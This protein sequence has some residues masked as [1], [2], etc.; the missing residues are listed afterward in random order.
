MWKGLG[1]GKIPALITWKLG[2]NSFTIG[3]T[4]ISEGSAK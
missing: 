2:S 3:N 4:I 1:T